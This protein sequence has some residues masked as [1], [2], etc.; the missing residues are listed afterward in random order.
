MALLM[1]W[2]PSVWPKPKLALITRQIYLVRQKITRLFPK[3]Y[4]GTRDFRCGPEFTKLIKTGCNSS[5]IVDIAGRWNKIT[6]DSFNTKT[7]ISDFFKQHKFQFYISPDLVA[8]LMVVL[9]GLPKSISPEKIGNELS[10]KGI[11]A[12]K[13]TQ[14]CSMKYGKILLNFL[15]NLSRTENSKKVLQITS[16][17]KIRISIEK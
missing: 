7:K 12:T 13:V 6:T 15:L 14:V 2:L 1:A 17:F 5:F 9:R 4:Y 16:L 10:D 8:L 11:D 3:T